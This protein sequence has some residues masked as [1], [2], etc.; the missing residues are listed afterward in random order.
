[1]ADEFER[2]ELW[3]GWSFE[4]PKRFVRERDA[5]GSFSAWD[6][7]L[8]LDIQTISTAGRKDGTPMRPTEMIG[9]WGSGTHD[10]SLVGEELI[11][12]ADLVTESDAGGPLLWLRTFTASTNRSRSAWFGFRDRTQL[13]RALRIWR[14]TKCARW[15]S[16]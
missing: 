9:S 10:Y 4:L 13:E 8:A 3:D 15:G 2:F 11:G 5:D 1:V 16:A 12:K 6:E 14:S 7:D